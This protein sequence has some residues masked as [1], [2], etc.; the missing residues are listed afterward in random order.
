MGAK[1]PGRVCA[2]GPGSS[3]PI[4]VLVLRLR[5]SNLLHGQRDTVLTAAAGRACSQG[6]AVAPVPS[7]CPRSLG[8]RAAP[9]HDV[10]VLSFDFI[11]TPL[12]G[13]PSLS[14]ELHVSDL[15]GFLP[16]P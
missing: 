2:S 11:A 14:A 6:G 15:I 12:G 3:G 4:V 13:T 16:R 8:V 9:V 10:R 1:R 7:I 5:Q